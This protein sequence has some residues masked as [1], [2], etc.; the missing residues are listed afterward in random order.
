MT[1]M[2]KY[3]LANPLA[4]AES[5]PQPYLEITSPWSLIL[6]VNK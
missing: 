5:N 2:Q 3:A 6:T 1:K 4:V